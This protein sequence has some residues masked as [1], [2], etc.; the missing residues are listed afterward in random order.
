MIYLTLSKSVASPLN[1]QYLH[2]R[3]ENVEGIRIGGETL[4][5]V[6]YADRQGMITNTNTGLRCLIIGLAKARNKYGMKITQER[7]KTL[8]CRERKTKKVK[9]NN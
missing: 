1:L 8:Q 7:R 2:K 4:A 9:T 6:R 5:T 3:E